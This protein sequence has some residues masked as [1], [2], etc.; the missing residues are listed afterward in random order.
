[1]VKLPDFAVLTKWILSAILV[2]PGI[3]IVCGHRV[4]KA[5]QRR[6]GGQSISVEQ[7]DSNPAMNSS[8]H[9][10]LEPGSRNLSIE[11]LLP[12]DFFLTPIQEVLSANITSAF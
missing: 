3:C 10:V 11:L 12:D 5:E 8:C 7:Q 2:S 6:G 1:M 9:F 4:K